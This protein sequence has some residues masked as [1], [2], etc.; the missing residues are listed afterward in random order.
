MYKMRFNLIYFII[1][2]E[3]IE[4]SLSDVVLLCILLFPINFSSCFISEKSSNNFVRFSF[5]IISSL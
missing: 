3:L 2:Y 1:N 4:L 5:V